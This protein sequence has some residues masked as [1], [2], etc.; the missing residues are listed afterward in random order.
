M[1]TSFP[2]D[3]LRSPFGDELTPSGTRFGP[4]LNDPI[5]RLDNLEVVLD[6]Q[7]RIAHVS[8]PMDHI[9]EF[10]DVVQVKASGWF[11]EDVQG[12][13]GVGPRQLGCKFDALSFATRKCGAAWPRGI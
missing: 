5:S 12:V 11:V 10:S 6:H 4:Q 7:D 8:Q 2:G 1:A 3:L 9:E 13:P